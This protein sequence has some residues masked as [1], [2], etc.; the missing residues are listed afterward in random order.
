MCKLSMDFEGELPE[1]VKVLAF[2]EGKPVSTV[3]LLIGDFPIL[4][5]SIIS[6]VFSKLYCDVN[7]PF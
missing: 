2:L 1:N 3:F 4:V 7:N 5:H 6:R